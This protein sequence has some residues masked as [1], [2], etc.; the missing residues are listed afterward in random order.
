ML[1]DGWYWINDPAEWHI[2]YVKNGFVDL[3]GTNGLA[4]KN[5]PET[6]VFV[7]PIEPPINLGSGSYQTKTSVFRGVRINTP[8]PTCGRKP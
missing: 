1:Q 5:I 8:C 4:A 2:G 6:W 3:S 7:G